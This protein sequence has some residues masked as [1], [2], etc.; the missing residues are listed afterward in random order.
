ML[1][2]GFVYYLDLSF[3]VHLSDSGQYVVG[4]F[5]SMLVI[6]YLLVELT[7]I[8]LTERTLVTDRNPIDFLNSANSNFLPKF[9]SNQRD[10]YLNLMMH[11]LLSTKFLLQFQFTPQY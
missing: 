10:S 6:Q 3:V 7:Y 9:Y 2:C 4:V 5:S 1:T 8:F 11:A